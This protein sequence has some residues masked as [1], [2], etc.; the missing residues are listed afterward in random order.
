MVFIVITDGFYVAQLKSGQVNLSRIYR[1]AGKF[2]QQNIFVKIPGS[3]GY[4]SQL[5]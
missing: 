5:L 2:R 3:R 1:S 4:F